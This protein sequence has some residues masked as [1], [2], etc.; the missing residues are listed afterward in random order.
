MP[1]YPS[2]INERFLNPK[3]SGDSFGGTG[4]ALNASFVC[5]AVL[6]ISLET[7]HGQILKATFKA[8]GCGFLLAAADVLCEK[9]TGA[10]ITE[11]LD[12]GK[13]ITDELGDF[14]NSRQHC[15]ELTQQTWQAAVNNFRRSQTND[16]SGEEI[17]ICTCFG[18]SERTIEQTIENNLLTSVKDVTQVCRAG[19][20]CGSCHFLIQEILDDFWRA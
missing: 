12:V 4:N 5:G 6:Q 14:E 2:K 8:A 19:G 13:I 16:W 3:N 9:I 17:L 18:V 7:N 1:F 11:N 10:A 20:G 15:L